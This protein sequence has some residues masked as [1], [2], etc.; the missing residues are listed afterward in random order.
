MQ[1]Q[2]NQVGSVDLGRSNSGGGSSTRS[3]RDVLLS[4]RAALGTSWYHCVSTRFVLENKQSD[5]QTST[6]GVGNLHAASD[7]PARQ[8]SIVK[9]PIVGYAELPFQISKVGIVE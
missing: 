6:E 1:T 7:A 3:I 5:S 8:L 9:S 2:T 4:S